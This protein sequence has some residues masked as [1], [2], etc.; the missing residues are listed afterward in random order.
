MRKRTALGLKIVKLIEKN[1]YKVF[2]IPFRNWNRCT[3]IGAE[4][5]KNR[6]NIFPEKN[7]MNVNNYFSF[8]KSNH[9]HEIISCKNLEADFFC[10]Y[11]FVRE[12]QLKYYEW[13]NKN[14]ILILTPSWALQKLIA[15]TS[16]LNMHVYGFGF[17][18]EFEW[19]LW[20]WC[21]LSY[22]KFSFVNVNANSV[23]TISEKFMYSNCF[24]V[25]GV[26]M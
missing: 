7:V 1:V 8:F 13:E 5:M 16:L 6:L 20:A 12:S 15:T 2:P 4:W 24:G 26:Y 23:W 21:N 17:G 10:S 3:K 19:S 14:F 22:L 11:V 18:F 25:A 9:N